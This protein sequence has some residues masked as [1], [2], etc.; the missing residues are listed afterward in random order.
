MDHRM[1]N[2]SNWEKLT[3]YVTLHKN[4]QRSN[5]CYLVQLH[6]RVRHNNVFTSKPARTGLSTVN[7][8]FHLSFWI[9]SQMPAENCNTPV[10]YENKLNCVWFSVNSSIIQLVFVSISQKKRQFFFSLKIIFRLNL[11]TLFSDFMIY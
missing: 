2:K 3:C 10:R 5:L 9:D 11:H 6:F 4:Y 1:I 8:F 7:C